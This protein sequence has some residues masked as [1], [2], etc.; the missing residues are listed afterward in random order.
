MRTLGVDA[1][2]ISPEPPETPRQAPLPATIAKPVIPHHPPAPP[3]MPAWDDLIGQAQLLQRS[4]EI[5]SARQAED[6]RKRGMLMTTPDKPLNFNEALDKVMEGRWI[7]LE[8]ATRQE[9]ER[10][11]AR[12]SPYE[13]TGDSF[14]F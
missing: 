3:A 8:E 14:D 6:L 7:S 4:S 5:E 2:L 11:A 1:R 10:H 9:M 12:W 13:T